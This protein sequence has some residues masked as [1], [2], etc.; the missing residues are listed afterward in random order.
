MYL[1]RTGNQTLTM[2]ENYVLD[3]LVTHI[4][5]CCNDRYVVMITGCQFEELAIVDVIVLA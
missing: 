2:K 1:G 5:I 4:C 3:H